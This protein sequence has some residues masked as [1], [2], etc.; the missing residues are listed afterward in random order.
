MADRAIP[1]RLTGARFFRSVRSFATSEVGGQARWMFVGLIAVLLAGVQP[2][3]GGRLQERLGA[4]VRNVRR[5]IAVNRNLGVFT[6]GYHWLIQIIPALVIAPACMD[7]RVDLGVVTQ[8]A[9]AFSTLVAAFSLIVTQFQSISSFA[10]VVARLSS[11]VDSAATSKLETPS[12]SEA[13]GIRVEDGAA[14]LRYEGLTLRSEEDGRVLVGGLS[15]S[16]PLGGRVLI[17]AEDE[18]A[19]LALFRATAGVHVR[20]KAP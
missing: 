15:A 18:A 17:R 9:M 13:P 16:I 1:H 11:L 7:G 6:T 12:T 14:G 19:T 4:L 5:I 8:S 3:L 20:G 10:A 2:R